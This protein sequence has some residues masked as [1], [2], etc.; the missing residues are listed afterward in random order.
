MATFPP[1]DLPPGDTRPIYS[2]EILPGGPW[3]RYRPAGWVN[4][5]RVDGLFLT[6]RPG[7]GWLVERQGP[8]WVVQDPV[9]LDIQLLSPEQFSAQYRLDVG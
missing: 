9:T 4:A 8:I 5:H 7:D 1:T 3:N 2:R 6:I